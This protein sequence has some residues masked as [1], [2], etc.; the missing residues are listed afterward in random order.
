MSLSTRAILHRARLFGCEVVPKK[1][2]GVWR[3]SHNAM[4]PHAVICIS[5]SAKDVSHEADQWIS[6]LGNKIGRLR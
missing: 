4:H 5:Q 1:G 6:N 2:S 3:I